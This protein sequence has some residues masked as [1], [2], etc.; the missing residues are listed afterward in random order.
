MHMDSFIFIICCT[1][2]I[3]ISESKEVKHS[4][5]SKDSSAGEAGETESD[6]VSIQHRRWCI[7][8]WETKE[9]LLAIDLV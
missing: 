9:T 2:I 3:L 4:K 7:I 5:E 8:L 1:N 6:Q